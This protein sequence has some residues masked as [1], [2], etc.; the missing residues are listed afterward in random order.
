MSGEKHFL[1]I[2]LLVC[3]ECILQDFF[4]VLFFFLCAFLNES[5]LIYDDLFFL[6]LKALWDRGRT[7]CFRRRLTMWER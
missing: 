1:N 7:T 3:L 4:C 5:F 2:F 6:S